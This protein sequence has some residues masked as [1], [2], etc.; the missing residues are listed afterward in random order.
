MQSKKSHLDQ[1]KAFYNLLSQ[2]LND[3]VVLPES[4]LLAN[5]THFLMHPSELVSFCSQEPERLGWGLWRFCDSSSSDGLRLLTDSQIPLHLRRKL[6][7]LVKTIF[8][9]I[10]DPYCKAMT[11]SSLEVPSPL[12]NACSL[13]WDIAPLGPVKAKE[14]QISEACI[15]LMQFQLALSNPACRESGLRGVEQWIGVEPKLMSEVLDSVDIESE[16][17]VSLKNFA[18]DLRS[19]L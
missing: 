10:F 8:E 9:Q 6:T 13:F 5:V 12:N 11:L 15:E 16:P 18:I 4:E 14:A 3:E 19:L 17:I 7:G 1:Q 2:D